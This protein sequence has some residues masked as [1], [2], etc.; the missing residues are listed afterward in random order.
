VNQQPEN[1]PPVSSQPAEVRAPARAAS[2]LPSKTNVKSVEQKKGTE[3]R[4]VGLGLYG[5]VIAVQ[6]RMPPRE[7]RLLQQGNVYVIDE[8][9]KQTYRQVPVVAKLGP[10]ITRPKQ[11]GQIGYVMLVNAPVPLKEGAVVTVVLG[12]YKKEHV[13]VR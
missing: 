10:L 9:T 5:G 7:A 3:L 6:F 11:E 13:R 4:S 2:S 8:K 1:P 12:D